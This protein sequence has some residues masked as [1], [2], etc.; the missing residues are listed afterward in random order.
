MT[1][2]EK[3]L[4]R[5]APLSG[6]KRERKTGGLCGRSSPKMVTSPLRWVKNGETRSPLHEGRKKKKTKSGFA[7]FT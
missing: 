7:I 4:S 6:E 3:T 2:K 5:K 1:L